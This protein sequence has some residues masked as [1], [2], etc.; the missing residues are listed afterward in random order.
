M[1]LNIKNLPDVIK[2]AHASVYNMG[3][4]TRILEQICQQNR[5]AHDDLKILAGR[6]KEMMIRNAGLKH[7]LAQSEKER[8]EQ[9][10][11][12]SSLVDENDSRLLKLHKDLND[13]MMQLQK[14]AQIINDEKAKLAEFKKAR[15]ILEER[16]KTL[17][18]DIIDASK[19]KQQEAADKQVEL[20][21]GKNERKTLE[22]QLVRLQLDNRE[23]KRRVDQAE[24]D[25]IQYQ[26]LKRKLTE[27]ASTN[28]DIK[29]ILSAGVKYNSNIKF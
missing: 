16:N 28:A 29:K 6:L 4:V 25:K 20:D 14:Q 10:E 18:K 26:D 22:E 27:K 2:Q 9:A 19:D 21:N 5:A 17:E 8:L 11:G 7:A 15:E 1:N 23:L 13:S 12:E 24:T 3:V